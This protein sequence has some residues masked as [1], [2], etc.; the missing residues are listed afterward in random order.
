[1]GYNYG[2]IEVEQ[3]RSGNAISV[4]EAMIEG[5]DV[6]GELGCTGFL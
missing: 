6:G 3:M 1:M 2:S 4:V 5:R